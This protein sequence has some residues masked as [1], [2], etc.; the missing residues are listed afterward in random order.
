[1]VEGDALEHGIG[2]ILSREQQKHS[3]HIMEAL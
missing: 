2:T 1:V 3:R